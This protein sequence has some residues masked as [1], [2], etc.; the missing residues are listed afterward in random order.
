[1]AST[2]A[3][4]R[5]HVSA[6][7]LSA[8]ALGL[9]LSACGEKKP[10]PVAEQPGDW[11]SEL[12][13]SDASTAAMQSAFGN[14]PTVPSPELEPAKYAAKATELLEQVKFISAQPP[15]SSAQIRQ[16]ASQIAMLS[17][18][19][20]DGDNYAS[21]PA[22]ARARATLKAALS[23]R[24]ALVYPVLRAGFAKLTAESMWEHNIAAA[25]VGEGK[26]TLRLT[27]GTFANNANI[28]EFQQ[29]GADIYQLTRY[30]RIEYRWFK[31]ADE[32]T[33]YNLEPPADS[34]VGTWSGDE[35]V[36]VAKGG[37]IKAVAIS[38]TPSSPGK[39]PRRFNL[40][41]TTSLELKTGEKVMDAH[42]LYTVDL[43]RRRWCESDCNHDNALTIVDGNLELTNFT[44]VDGSMTMNTVFYPGD[45]TMRHI[46][47]N[48]G[49]TSRRSESCQYQTF[50]GIKKRPTPY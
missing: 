18:V 24:Q 27:G 25:A 2:Q 31:G 28:K 14:K 42:F 36:E 6:I 1:M 32:F 38:D 22:A 10:E 30:R 46:D 41:C 39:M 43:D 37:V 40:V 19:V 21:D 9:A 7:I 17:A 35:F 48:R 34:A 4:R 47:R 8:A 13:R 50:T 49:D 29:S 23:K 45:K 3:V 16:T 11:R 15:S 33:Y 5:S 20:A 12:A 44:T 26:R